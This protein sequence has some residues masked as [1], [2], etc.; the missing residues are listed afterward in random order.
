MQRIVEIS[1]AVI[2]TVSAVLTVA[3]LRD[4]DILL[5][6]LK[7]RIVDVQIGKVGQ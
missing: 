5:A 6:D 1:V 3:T 4:I 2:I 7:A